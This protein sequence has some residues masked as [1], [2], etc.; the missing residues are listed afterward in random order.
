LALSREESYRYCA[1]LAREKAKN[2]YYS[3]VVLPRHKRLAMCAVYAFYRECDD[4]SDEQGAVAAR[5]DDWSAALYRALD[6]DT[7]GHPL[8]PA[9]ADT[10]HRFRIPPIYFDEM[11]AGVKSDLDFQQP[12]SFADLY[13]YCY[14]VAS[15]VGLTVTHIF[16][17][18]HSGALALAEKCGIAFQLTNILRD[19]GEDH[20]NGRIYL[21]RDA[22]QAHGVQAAD[23]AGTET[24]DALL[25]LLVS[26]GARARAY[27]E[28][29]RALIG[30]VERDSQGSLW[31]LIEIYDRL[32]QRLET[33]RFHVLEQR[34]AL[35]KLEKLSILARSFLR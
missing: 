27:F 31:A 32:L 29:S 22:M 28:E 21:P 20:R 33:H 8:W 24:P 4:L 1:R 12:Q 30:M 23:L 16:G 5:L 15:V 13:R 17:F 2:F 19:V 25:R 26:L 35:S 14:R 9:F 7:S 6:G 10:V 18:R 3:F 11:I 34:H